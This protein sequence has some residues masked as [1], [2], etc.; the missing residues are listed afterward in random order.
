MS[1]CFVRIVRGV[2]EVLRGV[3]A[4]A[5]RLPLPASVLGV[6]CTLDSEGWSVLSAMGSGY[7]KDLRWR[8]VLRDELSATCRASGGPPP[9][10]ERDG[11]LRNPVRFLPSRWI[12]VPKGRGC[13]IK[14]VWDAGRWFDIAWALF[15]ARVLRDNICAQVLVNR[16]ADRV[17]T[18]T[19]EEWLAVGYHWMNPFEV[20]IRFVSIVW[21][22]DLLPEDHRSKTTPG[23]LRDRFEQLAGRYKTYFDFCDE[24]YSADG[25]HG[26]HR[27]GLLLGRALVSRVSC[28]TESMLAWSRAFCDECE[29]QIRT[30]GTH[31]EDSTGYHRLVREMVILLS[32]AVCDSKR[33]LLPSTEKTECAKLV[34]RLH[35]LEQRMALL[36]A[37]IQRKA[38]EPVVQIGD[39]DGTMLFPHVPLVP[40]S[41]DPERWLGETG[42]ES[43]P[44]H[45]WDVTAIDV[46]TSDPG[47]LDFESPRQIVS[48][49]CGLVMKKDDTRRSVLSGRWTAEEEGELQE[50]V[51]DRF[52]L[53]YLRSGS[54][55]VILRGGGGGSRPKLAHRHDD[56]L[57]VLILHDNHAVVLDPGTGSYTRCASMRDFFRSGAAHNSPI[58]Q[59]CRA[60]QRSKVYF[61]LPHYTE[62]KLI[63]SEKLHWTAQA[64]TESVSK[65]ER[66]VRFVDA[67]FEIWD[68]FHD[69]MQDGPRRQEW[70]PISA[71]D[72]VVSLVYGTKSRLRSQQGRDGNAYLMQ[73]SWDYV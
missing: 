3:R 23:G 19:S 48:A 6:G 22:W 71:V 21:V 46:R 43:Y 29:R 44:W 11:W 5:V 24:E 41:L 34:E 30:D 45:R 61:D 51:F 66:H 50:H 4:R 26:N 25:K 65:V 14:A 42:A 69:P 33:S 7:A 37:V 27:L 68:E 70:A 54:S 39:W 49:V 52:G 40:P 15:Y 13:D 9:L 72:S 59:Q 16:I 56:G 31:Y 18:E 38:G 35:D 64:V 63:G 57:S 67:A 20:A 12:P 17:Q 58:E 53:V 55:T 60:A 36:D 10:V 47:G 62:S 32:L 1:S 73:V 2:V 28:D 8:S